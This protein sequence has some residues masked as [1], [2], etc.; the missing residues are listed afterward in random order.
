MKNDCKGSKTQF[1]QPVTSPGATSRTSTE[2]KRPTCADDPSEQA[3]IIFST[4]KLLLVS[5]EKTLWAFCVFSSAKT[6]HELRKRTSAEQVTDISSLQ[7]HTL[8]NSNLQFTSFSFPTFSYPENTKNWKGPVSSVQA[9]SAL[10]KT[11][12]L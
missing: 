8:V 3:L 12:D 9:Q 1:N 11:A 2:L 10:F 6:G 5:R 4:V 7:F